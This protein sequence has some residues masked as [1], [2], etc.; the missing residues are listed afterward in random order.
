[1][2]DKIGRFKFE[3]ITILLKDDKTNFYFIDT[4]FY[5]NVETTR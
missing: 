4:T 2:H 3:D 1:M 5:Y